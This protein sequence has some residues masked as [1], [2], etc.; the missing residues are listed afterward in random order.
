MIGK[1]FE[2]CFDAKAEVKA[3]VDERMFK[4]G[5]NYMKEDVK[6]LIKQ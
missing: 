5:S 1:K 6:N 2:K 3:K 4:F